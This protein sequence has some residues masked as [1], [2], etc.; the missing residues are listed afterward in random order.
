V[1]ERTF[2]S[3]RRPKQMTTHLLDHLP[4]AK[5]WDLSEPRKIERD[6]CEGTIDPII[7]N[8]KTN[9]QLT[10]WMTPSAKIQGLG[11]TRTYTK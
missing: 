10:F 5:D 8:T 2:K 1:K 6:T 4:G 9:T 11:L 3:S 7:N